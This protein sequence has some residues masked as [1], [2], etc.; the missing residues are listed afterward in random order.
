MTKYL[1]VYWQFI[2][3]NLSLLMVYRAN[4][5]NHL[6]NSLTWAGFLFV[7][8]SFL[9]ARVSSIAGWDRNHLL[10]L[11]SMYNLVIG[12]FYMI[13]SR[14]FRDLAEII[15]LGKLD[16]FLLKPL[17]SQFQVSLREV[18]IPGGIRVVIGIAL[19]CYM[20]V[21][22]GFSV[23]FVSLGLCLVAVIAAVILL[24]AMWFLILTLLIWFPRLE[25]LNDFLYSTSGLGKYPR[26]VLKPFG[27]M[28]FIL[29]LV[30]F[31]LTVSIP[32]RQLL[33]ELAGT[34]LLYFCLLALGVFVAARLFWRFALRFYSGGS[35]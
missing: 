6:L 16:M 5:L 23:S 14:G 26:E 4:L 18:N 30:P 17:D 27:G 25:N 24:Y 29:P 21:R 34:E 19:V 2:K 20:L 8:V 7:S 15:Y 12:L 22:M 31:F 11:T 33:G 13:F 32:T 28:I 10:L 35:V 1:R 9:T 3:V